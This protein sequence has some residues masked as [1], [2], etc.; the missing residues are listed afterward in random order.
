MKEYV[1][2]EL[3]FGNGVRWESHRAAIVNEL[4]ASNFIE[5][6]IMKKKKKR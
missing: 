6:R 2:V 3:G 1:D 4:S 5:G